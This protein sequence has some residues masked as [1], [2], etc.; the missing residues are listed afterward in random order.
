VDETVMESPGEGS[1][2]W[3]REDQNYLCVCVVYMTECRH[4]HLCMKC[5]CM[6]VW[7][8]GCVR[9]RKNPNHPALEGRGGAP[10]A[11]QGW[12]EG[13]LLLSKL[14][15]A[16]LARQLSECNSALTL[17]SADSYQPHIESWKLA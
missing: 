8:G 1:G 10:F 9:E 3:A 15:R 16:L 6:L 13:L 17:I 12:E 2:R 5:V 7:V 4:V 11:W 14:F